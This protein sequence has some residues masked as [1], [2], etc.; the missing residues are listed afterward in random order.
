MQARL[1]TSL[2]V[3]AH[4]RQRFAAGMPSFVIAKGD[5]DRGGVILKVNRFSHGITVFEQT[6]DFDG[7]KM[8]RKIGEFAANDEK[9]ADQLL[10]K[11]RQYD[12][13]I[14]LLEIEDHQARYSPDA[15]ISDF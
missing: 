15:P 9:S 7:N 4:L 2:W 5:A 14:W 12:P 1:K 11:K 6:L 13:D 3:E 8:W 10:A